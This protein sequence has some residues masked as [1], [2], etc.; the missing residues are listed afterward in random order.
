LQPLAGGVTAKPRSFMALGEYP[1]NVRKGGKAPSDAPGA[2]ICKARSRSSLDVI[3]AIAGEMRPESH[4][5]MDRFAI[6]NLPLKAHFAYQVQRG[7]AEGPG[8]ETRCG[9]LMCSLAALGF[10][11][12]A[13]RRRTPRLAAIRK[14]NGRPPMGRPTE[15]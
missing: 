7:G 13:D 14:K 15:S 9:S 2:G 4:F 1:P 8:S 6:K 10:G 5:Y 11:P 12:T 3:E